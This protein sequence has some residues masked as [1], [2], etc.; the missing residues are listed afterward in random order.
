VLT[1]TDRSI[2]QCL[3]EGAP[4][5]T[6][7]I[8]ERVVI[9]KVDRRANSALVRQRLLGLQLE[10]LVRSLAHQKPMGWIR[11]ARGTGALATNIHQTT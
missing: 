10:G 11:T 3:D 4:C 2:L 6:K 9:T 5:A 1:E 7:D 8:A